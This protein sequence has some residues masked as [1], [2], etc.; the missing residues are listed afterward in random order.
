MDD[1]VVVRS[2]IVALAKSRQHAK[3]PGRTRART[4]QGGRKNEVPVIGS[5]CTWKR[6][7]LDHFKVNIERDVDVQTMIPGKFFAFDHL[8]EYSECKST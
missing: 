4:P 6:D 2:L 3:R 7:E 1:F 5:S 8:E